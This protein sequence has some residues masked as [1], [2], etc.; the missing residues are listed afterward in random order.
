MKLLSKGRTMAA[1]RDPITVSC[2]VLLTVHL[3]GGEEVH[4][5]T[6]S[7]NTNIRLKEPLIFL[8][9]YFKTDSCLLRFF[10]ISGDMWA[11]MLKV[12][13]MPGFCSKMSVAEGFLFDMSLGQALIKFSYKQL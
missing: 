5:T 10:H 6:I 2:S 8:L 7:V 4:K 9:S 13:L 1:L 12:V 11:F 3:K